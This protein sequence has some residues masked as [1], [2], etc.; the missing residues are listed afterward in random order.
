MAVQDPFKLVDSQMFSE[1]KM[2]LRTYS[3]GTAS[4]D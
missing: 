2:Y 1:I 4:E 3:T